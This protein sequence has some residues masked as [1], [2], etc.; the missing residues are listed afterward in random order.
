MNEVLRDPMPAVDRVLGARA[1]N[2]ALER[3][4]AA[5]VAAASLTIVLIAAWL[6]PS[7]DGVGT[8]TQILP[9]R[10]CAWIEVAGMPC[11]TC[12]MTTAFA[13]AA[14]GQFLRSFLTQPMG[15]VLAML[16]A[17]TFW[18]S[19]Y[20]AATGSPIARVFAR[21]WRPGVVWIGAALILVSWGYKIWA[22][23]QGGGA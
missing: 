1:R 3:L 22:M 5:V 8:H 6:E 9:L 13:H 19:V 2:V 10:S 14:D 23:K 15:F 12:G 11:P 17:M 4:I 21:M 20:I 16:T 7:P 18:V